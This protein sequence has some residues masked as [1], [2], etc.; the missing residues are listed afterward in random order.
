MCTTSNRSAHNSLVGRILNPANSI[1]QPLPLPLAVAACPRPAL[2][3]LP[4]SICA[5]CCKQVHVWL[6]V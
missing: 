3:T 6:H 1:T 2:P 5:L 4:L